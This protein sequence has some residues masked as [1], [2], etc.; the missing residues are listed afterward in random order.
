MPRPRLCRRVGCLPQ[1]NYYKP[2]GVPLSVLEHVNLTVDEL[3]A[4][5]LADLGGLHQEDAAKRM[6]VSRQTL[7]RILESAHMKIADALVHGKALSIEG[8][9][10][11][12]AE[13]VEPGYPA[14]GGGRRGRGRGRG[15][16]RRGANRA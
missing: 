2:R 9:A 6:N 8:G 13:P 5:R 11:E 16:C 12:L 15:R 10:V 7:G 4:I 1:S 3:E 14:P